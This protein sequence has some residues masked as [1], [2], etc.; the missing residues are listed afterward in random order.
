MEFYFHEVEHGITVVA[1]DGGLDTQTAGQF[2]DAVQK[3][4]DAGLKR[5]IIDCDRLNYISSY[6]VG[7]LLRIHSHMAEHGGDVKLANVHGV[8]FE[9]LKLMHLNHTFSIYEDVPR[10]QLAF[11]PPD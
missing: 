3:L 2:H 10:A 1:V 11:R 7:T 4:V 6:G 8:I 9:V 5:L